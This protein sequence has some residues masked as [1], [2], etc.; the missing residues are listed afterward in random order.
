MQR[1]TL[2]AW[3]FFLQDSD[4]RGRIVTAVA[5]RLLPG[6]PLPFTAFFAPAGSLDS[7]PTKIKILNSRAGS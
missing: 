5:L 4:L 7:A 2:T 3:V 1:A 6:L